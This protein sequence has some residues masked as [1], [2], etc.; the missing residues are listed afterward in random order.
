VGDAAS[1]LLEKLSD[2]RMEDAYG[3]SITMMYE[4]AGG[5]PAADAAM[6][7]MAMADMDMDA[8]DMAMEAE[9]GMP[10]AA[11]IDQAIEGEAVAEADELDELS[12]MPVGTPGRA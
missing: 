7:D 3:I 6:D 1:A 12:N 5:A 4:P 2:A 9:T 8:A 11:A 10:P